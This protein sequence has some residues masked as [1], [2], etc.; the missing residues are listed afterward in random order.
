MT[1]KERYLMVVAG[2][3]HEKNYGL[4]TICALGCDRWSLG[5]TGRRFRGTGTHFV[6]ICDTSKITRYLTHRLG[7]KLPRLL[8]CTRHIPDERTNGILRRSSEA[9]KCHG[10]LKS[11]SL[12]LGDVA[13]QYCLKHQRVP[14]VGSHLIYVV[15][16]PRVP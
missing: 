12:I 1:R 15:E 5:S 3:H 10:A 7:G 9:R 2:D 8:P 14:I 4:R 6:S 16:C 11:P 13:I